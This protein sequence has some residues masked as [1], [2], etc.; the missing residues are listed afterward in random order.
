[1]QGPDAGPKDD[2]DHETLSE[3]A[4]ISGTIAVH[5]FILVAG[6]TL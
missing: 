4:C 1:M 2:K 6:L 3:S 5:Y